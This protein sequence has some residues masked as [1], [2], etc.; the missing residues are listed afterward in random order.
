ME[1]DIAEVIGYISRISCLINMQGKHHV[2]IN[3][4]GH[5]E[6]FEVS[7]FLGGWKSMADPTLKQSIS[8]SDDWLG[9]TLDK[10]LKD[11]RKVR[12]VLHK[13]YK[14][15]KI[16]MENCDYEIEEIKHYIFC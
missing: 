8:Y 6:N 5:V 1:K 11:L 12:D 16:N 3:D 4:S 15:G 14:N 7:L 9:G 13:I 2:F 10:P